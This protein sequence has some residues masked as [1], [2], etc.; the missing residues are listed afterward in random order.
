MYHM[1]SVS[2]AYPPHDAAYGLKI[3]KASLGTSRSLATAH[4]ELILPI[5]SLS[6]CST[7]TSSMSWTRLQE[8]YRQWVKEAEDFDTGLDPA[9]PFVLRTW[10]SN[11][12]EAPGM[13]TYMSDAVGCAIH[14]DTDCPF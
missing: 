10:S 1:H 5:R 7:L 2:T 3:S 14:V 9:E 13:R 6:P 4:Q 12:C 11:T 8:P